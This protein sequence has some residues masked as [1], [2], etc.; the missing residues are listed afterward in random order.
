MS[1]SPP[2]LIS[3]PS[4]PGE[5]IRLLEEGSEQVRKVARAVVHPSYN[6]TSADGDLALLRLDSR[7]KLGEF[8]VPVCL[9]P[10][11]G[12]FARGALAAVRLSTVSGWGKLGESGPE[13]LV[14]QRLEVPRVPLQD[15][16]AQTKLTIT[17]N[18]LCA[19]LPG[20]GQ[21]SCQGDSGGPLV[22]LYRNTWF[23][24]GVV[25]WGRGCAQE[26]LYGVYT[27]VSNYLGWISTIMAA[28]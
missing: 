27:R 1:T 23:L 28:E 26:G 8:V 22:T 3:S 5:H 9:P 20:G 17:E 10:A 2:P 6:V 14:L 4:P 13:S 7:V 18:M 25:S 16:R 24:T 12:D 19:G 15:C 21:D 11:G